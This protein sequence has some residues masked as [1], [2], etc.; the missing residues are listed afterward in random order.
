MSDEKPR[1][2]RPGFVE[3]KLVKVYLESED[4]DALKR[5]A[6]RSGLKISEFLRDLVQKVI[7]KGE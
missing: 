3:R 6:G 2:G 5:I 7:R 4:Y 1:L